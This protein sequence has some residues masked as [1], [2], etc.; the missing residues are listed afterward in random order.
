MEQ[1]VVTVVDAGAAGDQGADF[2]AGVAAATAAQASQN[3]AHAKTSAELAASTAETAVRTVAEV[4]GRVDAV[5]AAVAAL[6]AAMAERLTIIEGV[7]SEMVDPDPGP[8]GVDDVA[9]AGGPEIVAAGDVHVEPVATDDKP[10]PAPAAKKDWWFGDRP[11][12]RR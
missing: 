1:P 11:S 7:L 4:D 3:A 10:T 12:R 8:D 2:A 5:E 9:A 6:G